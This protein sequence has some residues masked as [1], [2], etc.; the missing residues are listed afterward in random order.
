MAAHHT[1]RPS[2]SP[3]QPWGSW[4]SCW[5]P[6]PCFRAGSLGPGLRGWVQGRLLC[7][8]LNADMCSLGRP[9]CRLYLGAQP[10][11]RRRLVY[12]LRAVPLAV[13]DVCWCAS[14]HRRHHGRGAAGRLRGTRFLCARPGRFS[15]FSQKEK[16]CMTKAK[17]TIC[18]YYGD[19]CVHN[20]SSGVSSQRSLIGRLQGPQREMTE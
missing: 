5:E 4:H 19:L 6:D 2:E 9:G 14:P 3:R 12:G 16:G 17:I 7:A 8:R 20:V 10:P 11:M 15:Y 1:A 18:A 13:S